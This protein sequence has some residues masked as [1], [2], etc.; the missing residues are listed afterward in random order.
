ME[1]EKWKAR[2]KSFE[3]LLL[4]KNICTPGGLRATFYEHSKA[5]F[6]RSI[7]LDRKERY[8]FSHVQRVPE[9]W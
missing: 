7:D 4:Y 6:F 9:S 1:N 2:L 5:V 8:G 3:P